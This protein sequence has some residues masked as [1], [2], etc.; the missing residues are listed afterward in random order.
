M[1]KKQDGQSTVEMVLLLTMLVGFAGLVSSAFRQN[2]YFSQ[3]VSAPWR[4]FSG[5]V[6]N[7]VWGEP[8]ATSL[9]HPSVFGRISTPEPDK[10]EKE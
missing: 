8:N 1:L 2:Q 3:M 5:L 4:S 9:Q 6:Q 10:A 7:G